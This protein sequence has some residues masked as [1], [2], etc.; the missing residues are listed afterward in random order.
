MGFSYRRVLVLEF[1]DPSFE[2]LEV[3]AAVPSLGAF[4]DVMA[5]ADEQEAATTGVQMRDAANA[6]LELFAPV[7]VSWNLEDTDGNPIPT[8]VD[9]LRSQDMALVTSIVT[10]WRRGMSEVSGP[11]DETSTDGAPHPEASIPMDV[12]SA[13][14]AS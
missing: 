12:L 1:E 6:L 5:A 8:T 11:L 7:L 9:G 4:M 10:A 14:R 2:G 3:K 13:P